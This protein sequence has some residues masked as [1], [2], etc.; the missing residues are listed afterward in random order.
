MKYGMK[1]AAATLWERGRQ[2]A[3]AAARVLSGVSRHEVVET[4]MKTGD[5]KRDKKAASGRANWRTMQRQGA[6][7]YG[8]KA[9]RGGFLVYPS[10]SIYWVAEDGSYRRVVASGAK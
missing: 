6:R 2:A 3:A 4:A 10:G 7:I 9:V 5:E 8:P 1:K